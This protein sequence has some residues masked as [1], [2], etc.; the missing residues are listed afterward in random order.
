MRC[1]LFTLL[2]ILATTQA[3]PLAKL[4][5]VPA[6]VAA[7]ATEQAAVSGDVSPVCTKCKAVALTIQ[8]LSETG[9]VVAEKKRGWS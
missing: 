7:P 2:A 4:G 6:H 1:A 8:V 3:V 5:E 9:Y